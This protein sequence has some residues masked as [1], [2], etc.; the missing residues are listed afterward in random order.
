MLGA[1]EPVD[2]LHRPGAV[3]GNHGRNIAQVRRFQLLDVALHTGG[4]QLEQVGRVAGAQ[5]C[6]GCF[7]V[8]AQPAQVD[9]YAPLFVQQLDG[10]IQDG[11]VGKSQEIHFEQAQLGHRVHG[12][13]GHHH[14]A[15]FIAA[16]RALQGHRFG[17]RFV[18][19]QNT[20]G[21]GAN[22]VDD[23]FQ[24]LG[25]VHQVLHRGVAF[26][27]LLQLRV[28]GQG[29][30]QGS[31]TIGHHARHPVNV[32]VA[33]PQPAAHIPQRRLGAPWFRR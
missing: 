11:E 21:V 9:A 29:I 1:D 27:G 33:H 26:V 25:I 16:G 15:V 19:N 7:V 8:Q 22:V 3:Q 20:G 32:A 5:Q 2:V 23:A 28:G 12:E 24:G 31:G 14:R 4:F 10:A 17:E 18:G 6:V 13:L 30:G